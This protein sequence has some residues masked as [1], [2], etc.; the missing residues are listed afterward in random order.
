MGRSSPVLLPVIVAEGFFDDFP[1]DLV[2]AV[3]ALGVDPQK[4][5]DAVPG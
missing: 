4:Y 5:F 3:D 1:L 2:P